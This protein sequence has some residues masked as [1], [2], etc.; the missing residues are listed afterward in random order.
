[1]QQVLYANIGFW[2]IVSCG[3]LHKLRTRRPVDGCRS[4]HAALGNYEHDEV[5]AGAGRK[6]APIF[7]IRAIGLCAKP[8]LCAGIKNPGSAFQG[9]KELAIRLQS[10]FSR[11]CLK[12]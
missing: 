5:V 9:S 2:H 11:S 10:L 6:G 1:M 3:K 12:A 8:D 7:F 4:L